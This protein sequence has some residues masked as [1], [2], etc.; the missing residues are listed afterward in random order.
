MV[1]SRKRNTETGGSQEG[2]WGVGMGVGGEGWGERLD[3]NCG[4]QRFF[5]GE[6]RS[7]VPG[8]VAWVACLAPNVSTNQQK[9]HSLSRGQRTILSLSAHSAC[10]LGIM[11]C[12]GQACWETP[13]HFGPP[14]LSDRIASC[15]HTGWT[16]LQVS[17]GIPHDLRKKQTE[18]KASVW[19]S[20]IQWE[21]RI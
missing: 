11:A 10:D 6:S 14:P 3:C 16:A 5:M 15:L 4:G 2:V 9:V 7:R 21:H 17:R 8:G 20:I 12:L 13:P 18:Y 19:F 1:I